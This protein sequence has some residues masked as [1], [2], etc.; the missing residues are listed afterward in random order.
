MQFILIQFHVKRPDAINQNVFFFMW[1]KTVNEGAC[2]GDLG[3]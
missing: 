3:Q 1:L 2:A